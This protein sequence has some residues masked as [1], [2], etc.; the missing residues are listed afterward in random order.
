MK[1]ELE[2]TVFGIVKKNV[3]KL[4]AESE[5]PSAMTEDEIGQYLQAVIKEIR[6]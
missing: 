5:V 3:D 1:Q 2:K 4:E 6:K